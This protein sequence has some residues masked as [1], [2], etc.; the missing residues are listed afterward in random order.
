MS[1]LCFE[2]FFCFRTRRKL[3][4]PPSPIV[5]GPA[6]AEKPCQKKDAVRAIILRQIPL[7]QLVPHRSFLVRIPAAFDLDNYFHALKFSIWTASTDG[8]HMDV[9]LVADMNLNFAIQDYRP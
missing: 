7:K 4:L 5:R 9:R 1:C 8:V 6:V 2:I 3:H